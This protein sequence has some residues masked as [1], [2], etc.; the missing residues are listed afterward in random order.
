MLD[1]STF[2]RQTIPLLEEK[3]YAINVEH[4]IKLKHDMEG[5][6]EHHVKE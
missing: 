1:W 5:R 2:D 6:E 4:K 3:Y